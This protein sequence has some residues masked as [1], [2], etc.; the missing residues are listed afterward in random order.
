MCCGVPIMFDIKTG[1]RSEDP[2]SWQLTGTHFLLIL[3]GVFAVVL[4][5][6]VALTVFAIRTSPGGPLANAYDESQT[7]NTRIEK[8]RLQDQSGW[9]AQ[10]AVDATSAGRFV[11]VKLADKSGAAIIG[12]EVKAR[13][14]HPANSRLDQQLTFAFTSGQYEADISGLSAGAWTL[15]L[16]AQSQG[17]SFK[18]INHVILH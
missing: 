12:A 14:E 16:E 15:V 9:R 7:Y 5:A 4:G 2:V 17:Q 10:V 13:L 1:P 3:L 6:N 8:M 18:S 11:R